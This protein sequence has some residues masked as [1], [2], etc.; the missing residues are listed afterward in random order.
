VL[1]SLEFMFLAKMTM[2]CCRSNGKEALTRLA[3]YA[4][5]KAGC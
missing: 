5:G 3:C 1:F 2:L 4:N